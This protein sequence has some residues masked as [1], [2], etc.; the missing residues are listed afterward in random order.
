MHPPAVLTIIPFL[1]LTLLS[2]TPSAAAPLTD[3]SSYNLTSPYL[4]RLL[5]Y[6]FLT[7][8]TNCGSPQLAAWD[9]CLTCRALKWEVP[10]VVTVNE[11]LGVLM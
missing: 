6:A 10:K 11:G 1:I 8:I 9:D 5:P 7:G 2:S 4:T 3:P